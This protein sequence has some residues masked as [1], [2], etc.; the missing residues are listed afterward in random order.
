MLAQ[1]RYRAWT[2]VPFIYLVPPTSQPIGL[3]GTI[4]VYGATKWKAPIW[5]GLPVQWCGLVYADGLYRLARLDP[6]G[7]WQQL[8]DGITASGL[9]QIWPRT[10]TKRQGLSPDVFYPG[11]QLRDGPAINPGTVQAVAARYYRQ[12]PFYGFRAVRE[13]GWLIHVPGQIA[14]LGVTTAGVRFVTEG[15]PAG[16]YLVLI[17]GLKELPIV[18][19]D[20]RRTAI[21]PPHRFEEGILILHLKGRR[22]VKIT[23]N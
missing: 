12:T 10:D 21:S 5:F 17:Q 2:A 14:D 20:G 7:P 11:A 1:A 22:E 9:Q 3:Y 19:I 6:G 13:R 4:A 23:R 15:W 16:G 18:H 8:A